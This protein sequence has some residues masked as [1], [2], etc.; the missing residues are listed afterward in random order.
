M[1]IGTYKMN[2][3]FLWLCS[4]FLAVSAFATD[5]LK[6]HAKLV[7]GCNEVSKDPAITAA[8]PEIAKQLGMFKWKNYYVVTNMHAKVP[9]K[10]AA[11]LVLSKACTVEIQNEAQTY[12]AKLF[13]E[14]KLLKELDQKKVIGESL[15]LAGDDKNAHGTAWFVILTP[16][17]T[18]P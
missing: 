4:C 9:E 17:D 12:I 16:H 18:K 3:T 2:R 14:G 11:K 7:W 1:K 15:V 8:S 10:G 5:D 6:L 13:G